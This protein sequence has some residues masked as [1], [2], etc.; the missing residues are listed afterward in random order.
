MNGLLS[1]I[2]GNPR[3]GRRTRRK[4]HKK[5]KARRPSRR[6]RVRA[7]NPSHHRRV[8]RHR[9]VARRRHRNPAFGGAIVQQ[10]MKAGSLGLAFVAAEA[11]GKA[12]NY[13]IFKGGDKG[14]GK[15]LEGV[16]LV[17]LKAGI[18]IG[19]YFLLDAMK[20]RTLGQFFLL[21]AGVSAI[22]EA[23]NQFVKPSLVTNMPWLADYDYGSLEGYRS[24]QLRGWAPQNG[25]SGW[26]PQNGLSGDGDAYAEGA[27][28]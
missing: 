19:G 22:A 21:G 5:A 16:A 24:G 10:L 4:S 23:Y 20:Q 27:Y 6:R 11:A 3:R 12:A 18:G 8:R 26:A 9:R 15:P 13:F 1:V 28:N 25:L 7:S 14:T 17:G 2:E